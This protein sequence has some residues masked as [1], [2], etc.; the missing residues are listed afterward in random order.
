M[1]TP[2]DWRQENVR[3]DWT[4]TN[5]TRLMVRW[6]HDSW[7]ADRNQW[8]DD[9]FPAVRSV[10]NQPGRSLVAQL[11]QNIGSTM[12]NS[13]TFSYSANSIDRDARRTTRS[14][15][16]SSRPP[17]PPCSRP[18]SSSRAAPGQPG[19]MW[20]SLGPYGGGILWNQAPWL[21]NQ[22]LFVLKDDYS[23]VFGKHFLKIGV[24]LSSNKKNEEPA[25][26]TQESVQVQGPAGFVGPNGFIQGAQTGNEIANWLLNGMAWNT[27]EIRTNKSV[28]QRWKDYEAYIAD[29]YKVSPRVTAD[30][31][32][33]L[34]H[35]TQ[36]FL[37]DDQMATFDPTTA[38][39][40]FGNSPVQRDALRARP[41]PVPGAGTAR[42]R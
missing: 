40:A 4:A 5:S 38:N 31:G 16:A 30:V 41:E 15:S 27:A 36:P 25:N 26:T 33:R 24:L 19:A 9:P 32:V 22:D 10:W 11:N 13:L 8:G 14:W 39:P 29:T 17:S 20:G 2:V 28:Q 34:S 3:L 18:A 12:V 23:A 21:N 1:P 6:T 37:A 42:W 35:F 7:K